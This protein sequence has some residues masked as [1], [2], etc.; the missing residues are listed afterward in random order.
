MDFIPPTDRYVLYMVC[1]RC[2][3]TDAYLYKRR[4]GILRSIWPTDAMSPRVCPTICEGC[5]AQFPDAPR[6][7]LYGDLTTNTT[8]ERLAQILADI[9]YFKDTYL[10]RS[11]PTGALIQSG[12]VLPLRR[13]TLPINVD[14]F[15]KMI[16][17]I[18][19][20]PMH[21]SPPWSISTQ[22]ARIVSPNEAISILN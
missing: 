19:A 11:M 20:C 21:E 13:E 14:G 12:L 16:L 15:D 2:T 9:E 7:M 17:G 8:I 10:P 4:I 6:N 18:E 5:I 22:V 3:C 1:M